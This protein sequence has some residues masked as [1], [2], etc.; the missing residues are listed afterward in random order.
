M[1]NYYL[2]HLDNEGKTSVYKVLPSLKL[3][4]LKNYGEEYTKYDKYDV[5]WKWFKRKIEYEGEE[6][7][8]IVS[9]CEEYFIVDEKINISSIHTLNEDEIKT[10]L[11]TNEKLST[12]LFCYPNMEIN[13]EKKKEELTEI[14]DE[15]K[16][17]IQ[18]Y[19]R[20][21]TME[22]KYRK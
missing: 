21:K 13:F 8:F 2:I 3:E 16:K 10:I 11:S 12:Y 5:F 20:K 4:I 18:N 19:F 9:S 17:N 1:N 15:N 14:Y 7:C 6:L 22:Y